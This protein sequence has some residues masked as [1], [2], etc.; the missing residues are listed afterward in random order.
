MGAKFVSMVQRANP[1][2]V[3]GHLVAGFHEDLPT[4][5]VRCWFRT[6]GDPRCES[7][8]LRTGPSISPGRRLGSDQLLPKIVTNHDHPPPGTGAGTDF[9]K[10]QQAVVARIEQ[11]E[12]SSMDS[13]AIRLALRRLLS[14][15]LTNCRCRRNETQMQTSGCFSCVPPNQAVTSPCLVSSI[16]EAW[17]SGK[18]AC[19]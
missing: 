10:Q 14:S 12:D 8:W 5:R 1:L 7:V 18:G 16:V 13:A 11:H 6:A 2:P 15:A 17:H 9:V 3:A 4:I 19:W